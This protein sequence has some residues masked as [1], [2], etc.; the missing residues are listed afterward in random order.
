MI[1][2]FPKEQTKAYLYRWGKWASRDKTRALGLPA[3]SSHLMDH[4]QYHEGDFPTEEQVEQALVELGQF[5][6]LAMEVT[7]LYYTGLDDDG[8]KLSWDQVAER[9]GCGLKKVRAAH[10]LAIGYVAACL[11]RVQCRQS[12]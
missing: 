10:N 7:K 2:E 5:D 6:P 11:G 8:N 9:A 1:D 12:A 3:V 4:T